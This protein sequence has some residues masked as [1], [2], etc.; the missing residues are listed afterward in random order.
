[1]ARRTSVG[2]DRN[3]NLRSWEV[4][5]PMVFDNVACT[6]DKEVMSLRIVSL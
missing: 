3:L 1:M 2:R 5:G 4:L 6:N